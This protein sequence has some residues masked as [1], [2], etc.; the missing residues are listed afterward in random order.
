MRPTPARPRQAARRDRRRFGRRRGRAHAKPASSASKD[1]S[2]RL[3]NAISAQASAPP[4]ANQ[5]EIGRLRS[6]AEKFM[7]RSPRQ[8]LANARP[9]R[10]VSGSIGVAT[11][12][13]N[14]WAEGPTIMTLSLKKAPSRIIRVPELRI[15]DLVE[16]SRRIGVT[17]A[18]TDLMRPLVARHIAPR[19]R[20]S[21][22]RGPRKTRKLP[23]LEKSLARQAGGPI[24]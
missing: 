8:S 11:K 13:C 12:S 24:W 16:R 4:A 20:A 1:V 21:R 19:V 6:V 18:E 2:G 9:G 15:E 7:S 5:E 22:A 17:F 10:A 23:R 14:T 3:T